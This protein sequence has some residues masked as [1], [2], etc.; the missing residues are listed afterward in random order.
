VP[1]TTAPKTPR[2]GAGSARR[3][4]RPAAQQTAYDLGRSGQTPAPPNIFDDPKLLDAYEE[5]LADREDEA[6]ARNRVAR[7]PNAGPAPRTS[8]PGGRAPRSPKQQPPAGAGL[9]FEPQPA[10]AGGRPFPT[11]RGALGAVGS[12]DLGGFLLGL[13]VYALALNYIKG[14]WSG[15]TRA[16]TDGE[17]R[18]YGVKPWLAAKFLNKTDSASAPARGA[19]GAESGAKAYA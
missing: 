2:P 16:D 14:G 18:T 1:A 17:V 15:E 9:P 8:E 13:A 12:D 6:R 19:K 4:K 11:L 7:E 5:G 3:V 10:P